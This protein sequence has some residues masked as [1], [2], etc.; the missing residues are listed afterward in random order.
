MKILSLDISSATIGWSTFIIESN[1]ISLHKYGHIKPLTKKKAAGLLHLRLDDA[2][3]AIKEL[4]EEHQP[5]IFA[6]E[7]YALKFPKGKSSANTIRILS[8]F[9]ETV[10]LCAYQNGISKIIAINVN[11]ARKLIKNSYDF[12]IKEKED[13][14]IF[15]KEFLNYKTHLNKIGNVKKECE[16][17]ADSIVI[18][19]AYFLSKEQLI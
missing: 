10:R 19:V 1:L 16:D 18:G 11:T 5:D 9:N 14:I 3:K 7:D 2:C 12:E 15:A 8:V 4:I 6:V 17:E 13:S